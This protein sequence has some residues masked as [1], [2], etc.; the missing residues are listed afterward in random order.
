MAKQHSGPSPR[1]STGEGPSFDGA[2][3]EAFWTRSS[4]GRNPLADHAARPAREYHIE[5]RG[6]CFRHNNEPHPGDD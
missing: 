1:V 4:W 5:D 2:W 3:R 6:P